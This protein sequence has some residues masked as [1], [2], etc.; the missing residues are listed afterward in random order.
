MQAWVCSVLPQALPPKRE[1]TVTVRVRVAAPP[2]H[3]AL[4]G[5]HLD[6]APIW[7]LIAQGLVLQSFFSVR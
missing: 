3:L 5:D 1:L 7:Q 4:Q 6:Q 2:P